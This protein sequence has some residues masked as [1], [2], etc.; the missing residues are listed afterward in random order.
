MTHRRTLLSLAG[1]LLTAALVACSPISAG[2]ITQKT[3][4]PS[5]M[6]STTYCAAY[7]AKGI[8]SYWA[9]QWHTSPEKWRFDIRDND[10]KDGW[11]YVSSDTYDSHQVGDWVDFSR[12]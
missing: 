6:Y 3:H 12:D 1:L 11:V 5:Y 4:E 7:G 10:D 8:C 2:T 9:Q